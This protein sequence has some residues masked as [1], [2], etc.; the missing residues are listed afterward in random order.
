LSGADDSASEGLMSQSISAKF[1]LALG[2]K[3]TND[4]KPAPFNYVAPASLAAAVEVLAAANGD[5]K[6]MAGG[7]S[8][9]PLLNFR[10]ARPRVVVD[11]RKNPGL[12]F[13]EDR[14]STIAIGALTRHADVAGKPASM[15]SFGSA[16]IRP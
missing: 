2:V 11:L 13:I 4:M 12:S 5:G 14:G 7:Q 8:L 6:I 1:G 3:P 10:I 16:Y 15:S 9:V